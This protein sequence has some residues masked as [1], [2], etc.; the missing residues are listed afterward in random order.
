MQTD[1]SSAW[2]DIDFNR[3]PRPTLQ[4]RI[5]VDFTVILEERS[6]WPADRTVACLRAQCA[7]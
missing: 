5:K 6:D 2:M 3:A 4:H 7:R 1:V